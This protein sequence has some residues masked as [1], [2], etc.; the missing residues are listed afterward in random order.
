MRHHLLFILLSTIFLS[1]SCQEKESEEPVREITEIKTEYS[2]Y[3]IMDGEYLTINVIH[4][5]EDL[6]APEYDLTVADPE[7]LS[8]RTISELMIHGRK[9]GESQVII[10]VKGHPSL[11]TT[12]WVTVKAIEPESVSLNH[13]SAE[14]TEGDVITLTAM[15][16][17]DNATNKDVSWSSSD[18]SVA[19]VSDGVVT[20]LKPGVAVIT[21]TTVDG[22]KTASCD[23]RVNAKLYP[24]TS[25]SLDHT[26]AELT[27]G[28]VMT[29]TAMVSPDN[30]TNKDV[31]WSSSDESVATVSDGVVTALKPGVAV[32]TVTTEDGGKTASCDVRVK[33]RI[34]NVTGVSLN[35]TAVEIYES[36]E[37]VLIAT[38]YPANATDKSITWSVDN[39][40]VISVENGKVVAK[41]PGTAI[42]SVT[43]T[44]G[45]YTA[46]CRLNVL[47]EVEINEDGGANEGVGENKG[48]W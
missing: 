48:N 42:I 36:E 20:A 10:I 18:E 23:V 21:V 8:D 27:E 13:T 37:L 3:E 22:G 30:T 15:V 12:C 40:E 16:S 34:Y 26:S 4:S 43:S 14:L 35:R 2:H 46:T 25:V 9:P 38:V 31:S 39:P 47:K 29:L 5:P 11:K 24:V 1:I 41:T 45:N 44:D 7:V 33:A 6:S 17:P 19:T 28:D 32:I